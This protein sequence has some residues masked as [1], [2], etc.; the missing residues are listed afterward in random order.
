MTP[1]RPDSPVQH[2]PTASDA[3]FR[4]I[5]PCISAAWTASR[6]M[7]CAAPGYTLTSRRPIASRMAL[8]LNVVWSSAALPWT[9]ETP[10][11]S[12][13]GSWAARRRAYASCKMMSTCIERCSGAAD[14]HRGQYPFVVSSDHRGRPNGVRT[15]SSHSGILEAVEVILLGERCLQ[16]A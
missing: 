10:R 3:C 9:V 5:V 1:S 6:A 14:S 15:Q 7:G 16:D 2:Q 4:L 11:S 8:V 12:T 13:R